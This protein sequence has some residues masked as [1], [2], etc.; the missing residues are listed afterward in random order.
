MMQQFNNNFLEVDLPMERLTVPEME[1][2]FRRMKREGPV[3][4]VVKINRFQTKFSITSLLSIE[5]RKSMCIEELC[6]GTSASQ[7]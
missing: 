2:G 6:V 3:K 7:V 1:N 4:R 5:N